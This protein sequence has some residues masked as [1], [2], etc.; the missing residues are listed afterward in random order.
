M[1]A[2]SF[3]M[4]QGRQIADIEGMPSLRA[5]EIPHPLAGLNEQV[6]AERAKSVVDEII[7]GLTQEAP[8]AVKT[9][10]KKIVVK[11]EPATVKAGGSSPAEAMRAVN[12]LFHQKK[13][14][15]GF[16]IIPPTEA[17]VAR[18]LTGTDRSPDEIIGLIPPH[19]GKAT[20]R[21]IAINAVMAGAEPAYLPVIIAAVEAVTAPEFAASEQAVWGAAGMQA[22]TGS[23]SP[24]LIINGPVAAD[25]K[26]E[27]GVGCFGRGHRA[28]AAIGRSLR[29]V[30]TNT[31][32][33]H[34]GVS[35]MK[36]HG[37]AQEFTYCVAE[38]DRHPVF[39]GKKA[40]WQPLNVERGFAPGSNTVTAAAAHPP[41][42]INE[43]SQ[44]GFDILYSMVDTILSVGQ[45]PYE[46]D[47]QYIIVLN[48]M[49]AQRLAEAGWTKE[50]IRKYLYANS[51]MPWGKYKLQYL[52][53]TQPSWMPLT[54]NEDTSIH[55]V[56]S[57]DSFVIMVAGGECQY[58]DLI[59]CSQGCA[60]R[61]IKLPANWKGVLAASRLE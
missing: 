48:Q 33:A 29:L 60:T 10:A 15:D 61:E 35:D 28:N 39:Q 34:L 51:V 22:T 30:L 38:R 18:M 9:T 31:G 46:L 52:A 32:G 56:D 21:N 25:L 16:P 57:P 54:A 55:V 24:L 50:D 8:A 14:T 6:I 7:V 37:S 45:L 23:V 59:R 11:P 42:C 12:D 40:A 41:M 53:R 4:R 49:H 19:W 5:V 1:I 43:V 47:W 36:C 26:V 44:G 27:S 2:T 3:F 20:V 58:S 17:E 13:W